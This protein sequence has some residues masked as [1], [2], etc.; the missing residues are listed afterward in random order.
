MGFAQ[1][2]KRQADDWF[3]AKAALTE[4]SC[5]RISKWI[6]PRCRVGESKY[7]LAQHSTSGDTTLR[8]V[9]W[10]GLD[11]KYTLHVGEVLCKVREPYLRR[12]EGCSVWKRERSFVCPIR[13]GATGRSL[14][15]D[16]KLCNACQLVRINQ[17]TRHT[18]REAIASARLDLSVDVESTGSTQEF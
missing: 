12:F 4:Q 6:S 9:V 1:T 3:T 13:D 17:R 11:T 15:L 5:W 2:G 10:V 16:W 14:T 7:F 8:I 18:K